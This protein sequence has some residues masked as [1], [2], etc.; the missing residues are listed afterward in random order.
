MDRAL[1]LIKP[2]VGWP[3]VIGIYL[4]GSASRPFRDSLSDYDFEVVLEDAAYDEMPLEERHVFAID[5]GPP[6]RVDH[7]F[8]LRPWSELVALESSPRDIDHYPFRH[9]RI[10]HDP[11]GRLKDLFPRLARL[12]EE[13]RE[14]RLKVHY[15]E[16]VFGLG[17]AVKCLHRGNEFETRL[18]LGQ[19]GGALVKLLSIARGSWAPTLHWAGEELR[20]LGVPEDILRQVDELLS[21]PTREGCEAVSHA[22]EAFLNDLGLDFHHDRMGLVRW[23]FLTEEGK[24]A[25]F[26]WGIR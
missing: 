11:Q 22:L 24:R 23:A 19:A 6:R 8:Y 10:L 13:V 21:N 3:G 1:E 7:E 12:P 16:A 4:V 5:K 14:E 2:Y 26:T 18:V 25:F 20:L 15:L 9:A 17:R